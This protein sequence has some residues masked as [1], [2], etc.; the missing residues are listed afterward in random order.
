MAWANRAA[1][2]PHKGNPIGPPV[3]L[4]KVTTTASA[5][6]GTYPNLPMYAGCGVRIDQAATYQEGTAVLMGGGTLAAANI[7]GGVLTGTYTWTAG[8]DDGGLTDRL[9]VEVWT[10]GFF[11]FYMDTVT[12]ATIGLKVY[13]V[14]HATYGPA[15]VSTTSTNCV[16]V[17]TVVEVGTNLALVNI[18]G[19]ACNAYSLSAS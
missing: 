13:E 17:G 6:G 19:Y 8:Y 1:A 16:C 15:A 5:T 14:A 3:K 10:Q 11:W 4:R 12:E 9:Y 2:W 7:F 18:G